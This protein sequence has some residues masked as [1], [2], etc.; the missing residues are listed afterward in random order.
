VCVRVCVCVVGYG[1]CF[2]LGLGG[3]VFVRPVVVGSCWRRVQRVF[4]NV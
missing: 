2:I 4:V 3:W 1:V